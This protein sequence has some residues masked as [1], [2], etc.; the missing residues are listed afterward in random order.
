MD[1]ADFAADVAALLI[2]ELEGFQREIEMFPDDDSVWAVEP[3]V[4]NAA[5]NLALHVAGN[6][7]HFVGLKL[8][9]VAY[10]R[11]RGAEFSR[12][13]GTRREL[14][15]ELSR[16]IDVVRDVLPGLTA[17]QLEAPFD[18]AAPGAH[19][20]MHRFLVHLCAHAAYHVGQAGYLRRIVTGDMRSAGNV[21]S[22]RLA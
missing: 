20:P 19:V 18:E 8:G 12:R 22:A 13:S 16:A 14:V 11:D 1:P 10:A 2:R 5:G 6:L 7:R 21:T 9:G 15:A 3:G 17:D 4:S